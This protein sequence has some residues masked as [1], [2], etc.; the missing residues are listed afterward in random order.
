MIDDREQFVNTTQALNELLSEGIIP[1]VNENDVVATEELK[2]GDNDRLSAIVS[3]IVDAEKLIIVTNK[4]GLYN[5][6][7]DNN[8]DAKKIDYIEYDSEEL[9]NLIPISQKGE[10]IGGFST[11][12]MAAQISGFSGIPTQIISWSKENLTKVLLNE[13]VGTYITASSKKI[14][15]RKLWIAYGM[16]T[17]SSIQIDE[18]AK[19]ALEKNASLLS[20]GVIK[21]D[22][23]FNTGDGL[24]VIYNKKIVAKGIAKTD[25]NSL[26]SDN[27]L[28]CLL[29]TSPSPRD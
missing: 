15:L 19:L 10:G 2:F 18:G 17:A 8:K 12:I 23:S 20:N 4:E 3:I 7:P 29:Y 21:V 5:F 9:N 11:K 6:N 16:S 25:S 13:K 22:N 28:I 14:R 24:S 1:V 26:S 27:L